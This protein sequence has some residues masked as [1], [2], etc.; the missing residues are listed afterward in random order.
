MK[1]LIWLFRQVL[2]DV[3]EQS[4]VNLQKDLDYVQNRVEYEGLSF[5]TITL[6]SLCDALE[7]GLATGQWPTDQCT[8]FR[9]AGPRSV[10]PAFM[11]GLLRLVFHMEDG[12]L[13]EK[14]DVNAI[15]YIRVLTRM[16]KKLEIDCSEAR[17]AK[18]FRDF[19]ECDSQVGYGVNQHSVDLFGRVADVLWSRLEGSYDPNE[20]KPKHG[21][22]ATA[23]KIPGNRKFE[24]RTWYTR[25][26]RRVPS[27]LNVIPNWN[28]IEALDAVAFKDVR[29]EIPVRVVSVP[30][31][32][33]APRIIAIEPVHMQ[34][35]QQG[36]LEFL[37]RELETRG[38]TAGHVNF[39]DQSVNQRLARMGSVDGSIATLDLSEASDRVSAKLVKRMLRTAPTLSADLFACRS[40]KAQTPDG[41]IR[42]LRKFAS[43][44]SAVCFPV[45]SMYFF[46]AVI[47]AMH[48]RDGKR[49]STSSV[50]RYAQQV[51]V[52]GDDLIVPVDYAATVCTYFETIGLKVNTKKSFWTGK[53]RESCGGD[54]YD[55]VDV[56]S[57]YYHR[58]LET[59]RPSAKAIV[60][61]VSF[62]NQLY[63]AGF[64][65]A[66]D[67]LR[68]WVER[69][70]RHKLPY[71]SIDNGGLAWLHHRFSSVKRWNRRLHRFEVRSLSVD[72]L[73]RKDPLDD[74]PALM[75]TFLRRR[76]S[77]EFQDLIMG[78]GSP[79][80]DPSHLEQTVMPRA[81]RLKHEWLSVQHR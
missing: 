73:K 44:G 35:V 27:D 16:F 6:P 55:G 67:S 50:A 32:L 25:L 60:A 5:L 19:H 71:T 10:L 80:N 74:M 66:A 9:K 64:W 24:V 81:I 12:V 38:L 57:I 18:A 1:S 26:E 46:T 30:K 2:N 49:P 31:T 20:L 75:K 22:G 15:F 79:G 7:R 37:T 17:V 11:Q 72:P 52:Y 54:F 47:S 62:V 76:T 33:K 61:N 8:A 29:D 43:M 41:R 59:H 53:F 58:I 40:S 48:L 63:Q 78:R 51:Y 77:T 28:Y 13:K 69:S 14:P 21:P 65:K 23:E 36:L 3:Q 4:A 45:E 70:I 34:Y 42:V 68:K 56:K 39:T